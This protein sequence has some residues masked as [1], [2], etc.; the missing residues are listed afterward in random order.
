MPLSLHLPHTAVRFRSRS[1]NNAGESLWSYPSSN[2]QLGSVEDQGNDAEQIELQLTVPK[3]HIVIWEIVHFRCLAVWIGPGWGV[4]RVF[5]I[6]SYTW[7]KAGWWLKMG[8]L[9]NWCSETIL[10]CSKAESANP[11]GG[12]CLLVILRASIRSHAL[13]PGKSTLSR[14][15]TVSLENPKP[16]PSKTHLPKSPRTHCRIQWSLE[17][18]KLGKYSKNIKT[19]WNQEMPKELNPTRAVKLNHSKSTS[20]LQSKQVL[21]CKGTMETTILYQ[22]PSLPGNSLGKVRRF[23]TKLRFERTP[24]PTF[25]FFLFQSSCHHVIGET[26]LLGSNQWTLEERLPFYA[27][28]TTLPAYYRYKKEDKARWTRT[29]NWVPC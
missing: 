16:T 14:S 2:V 10:F 1:V 26:K 3:M 18:G 22:R 20:E 9:I 23:I 11:S 15:Q 6:V 25:F 19:S 13:D 8:M 27:S 24:P 21:N 4:G 12:V 5:C 29:K 28:W 17:E 7:G